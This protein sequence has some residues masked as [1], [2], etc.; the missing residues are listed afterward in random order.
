MPMS[1]CQN[2]DSFPVMSIS[3][4]RGL[5]LPAAIPHLCLEPSPLP[6]VLGKVRT[7]SQ[8]MRRACQVCCSNFPAYY[9]LGTAAAEQLAQC[10]DSRTGAWSSPMC[11]PEHVNVWRLGL[12]DFSLSAGARE[13]ASS[14][15]MHADCYASQ[16]A[17]LVI[18]V[19]AG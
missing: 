9:P 7:V 19:C 18:G 13:G 1:G 2:G 4:L 5:W 11:P 16:P 10:R 6:C 15:G 17:L 12:A 3:S 8:H 14:T